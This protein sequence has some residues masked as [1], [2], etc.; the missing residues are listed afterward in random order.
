MSCRGKSAEAEEDSQQ[1]L[2]LAGVD[3]SVVDQPAEI[4]VVDTQTAEHLPRIFRFVRLSLGWP[5]KHATVAM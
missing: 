3:R 1:G 4:A 5:P 2:V